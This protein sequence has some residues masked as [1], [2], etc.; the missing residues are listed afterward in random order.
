MYKTSSDTLLQNNKEDVPFSLVYLLNGS[1]TAATLL[2]KAGDIGNSAALSSVELAKPG[3][4]WPL[5]DV[6]ASGQMAPLDCS[7]RSTEAG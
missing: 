2:G 6:L 1:A 7:G 4:E 5:A 3:S